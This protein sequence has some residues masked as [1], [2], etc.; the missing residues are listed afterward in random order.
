M[1]PR[2]VIPSSWLLKEMN[3]DEA[4]GHAI[5]CASTV[6]ERTAIKDNFDAMWTHFCAAHFT[7]G[8]KIH[9]FE[10]TSKT[11]AGLALVRDGC[12][13]AYKAVDFRTW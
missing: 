13:T 1:K 7:P 12:V 3:K 4:Y 9:W 10:S 8:D 11:H 5:L 6:S 2:D